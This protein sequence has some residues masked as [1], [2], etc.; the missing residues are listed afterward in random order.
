MIA[1]EAGSSTSVST[2]PPRS[3]SEHGNTPKPTFWPGNRHSAPE[4]LKQDASCP[5]PVLLSVGDMPG[6]RPLCCT[7]APLCQVIL[8]THNT[9]NTGQ[10]HARCRIVTVGLLACQ[11]EIADFCLALT[12]LKPWAEQAAHSAQWLGIQVW[13]CAAFPSLYP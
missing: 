5:V 1:R 7:Y 11:K 9:T 6:F 13:S 10:R 4:W 8:Q 3:S 2:W 12:Q